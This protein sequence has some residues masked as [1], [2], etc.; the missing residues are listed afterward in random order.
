MG[1][2]LALGGLYLYC[3]PYC[4]HYC[5]HFYSVLHQILSWSENLE[6][7]LDL[8]RGFY[9]FSYFCLA[10]DDMICEAVKAALDSGYRMVDCAWIYRS[11]AAV[12]AALADRIKAGAVTR[13]ELFISTKVVFVLEVK[14]PGTLY[15]SCST[16]LLIVP[17]KKDIPFFLAPRIFKE[18]IVHDL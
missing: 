15:L 8:W 11:E 4:E 16:S 17:P 6:T 14:V 7:C 10:Q 9:L 12:G 18:K 5:E 1:P 3:E 13:N 2:V